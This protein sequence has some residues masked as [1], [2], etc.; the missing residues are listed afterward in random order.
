MI[1]KVYSTPV[2][3]YCY[4]LKE[5]LK[6]K[7]VVFEDIDVSKDEKVKEEMV[8]NSGQMGVPVVEID[9]QFVIGFDRG[10]LVELLN[11]QD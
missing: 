6:S 8:K 1:V 2:C 4:T 10:K 7:G 9:G 3:P 5:Y 11:I